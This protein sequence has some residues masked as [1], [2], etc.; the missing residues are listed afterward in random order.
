VGTNFQMVREPNRQHFQNALLKN[1]VEK[2]YINGSQVTEEEWV[3]R[4]GKTLTN[5]GP[6]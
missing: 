5:D 2:Y 4:G 1:G 6:I 3:A